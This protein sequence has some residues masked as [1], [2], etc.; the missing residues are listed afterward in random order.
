MARGDEGSAAR[1]FEAM[2]ARYPDGTYADR[3]SLL[4]AQCLHRIGEEPRA[5]DGYRHVI[6]Q[7]PDEYVAD[8]L[9]G[10]AVIE[11]AGGRLQGAGGLVDQLLQRYPDHDITPAARVLRG[12]VSFDE[13][14][15]DRALEQ[16]EPL[17]K[18]A[19]AY[20]DDAE[21]WSAKCL[22]RKGQADEAAR[23]LG[24]ALEQFPESELL[25]QMTYDRAVALLR[26]GDHDGALEVLADFR[27]R[28]GEHELAADAVH[29]TAAT[30][31]QQR[32]YGESLDEC[33]TFDQRFRDHELAPD[34][35]FLTAENLFLMKRYE[36]AADAYRALLAHYPD[37]RQAVQARYRLGLSLYHQE[38]FDDAEPLLAGV[39]DGGSTNPEFRMALLALGDG[40]FQRGDWQAAEEHLRYYLDVGSDQPS[41]DDALL[42]LGL[43]QQ[44]QGE[45]QT[46]LG[47]LGTLLEQHPESSHR[48][49]AQFES[50]QILVELDRPDEAAAAFEQVL[51]AG[52]ETQFAA[53]AHNHLGAI[54]LAQKRHTDAAAHFGQSADALVGDPTA[55]ADALFQQGQALMTAREFNEAVA[56]FDRI[57]HE[58]P[59]YEGLTEALALRAIALARHDRAGNHTPVLTAIQEVEGRG[60][61]TLDPKLRAS[62]LYEKAWALRG[63][64]RPD[65]AA[66]AYRSMLADDSAWGDLHAHATLELA[67]IEVE[68]ERHEQAAQLLR[69]LQAAGDESPDMVPPEVRRQSAHRLGLCE[70]NLDNVDEA[71]RLLEVYLAG[72]PEAELIPSARLLCAE[73]HFRAGRHQQAIEH[74]TRVVEDTPADEA[75]G[76]A[77]LRLG[78]CR[79]ALQDWE[80]SREAFTTYLDRH[81]AS[82][83]W[84]QAQFGIG[85]A[86]ENEGRFD[87]AIEA[88]RVVVER[89]Q[90]PTAARAQFQIG[91]CLFARKQFKEATT[92]LLKVDILYAYPEWSAAALYEAGRCFQEMGDPVQ[93]RQQYELLQEQHGHTRWAQMAGERLEELDETSLP[94]H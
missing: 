82:P 50:G 65:D 2:A 11:H 56:V 24:R 17:T 7:G 23:R 1:R 85:W 33:R 53:H 16:L 94:G 35:A 40:H 86:L 19:G 26:S 54:A 5:A 93:A 45:Q 58:H 51:T 71:A 46:A 29:L 42:K 47:T 30:L 66:A 21:Y 36:D 57:K 91:E 37:H 88:Y 69:L 89:H 28:Y 38:A 55:A 6:Q 63:L 90:G 84:F 62:L 64:G 74:L 49:H 12:R 4:L 25:P 81:A 31:H 92:E 67:E 79:A 44:R 14:E 87:E 22:L 41:A 10:L 72:E 61:D 20:R 68:A 52:A 9:Y 8:A 77:L 13:A 78:E 27:R 80:P 75:S 48:V 83:M 18:K 70:Y 76:P 15:Y 60:T 39:T 73:A 34:V 43:A 3:V 59:S 32:R